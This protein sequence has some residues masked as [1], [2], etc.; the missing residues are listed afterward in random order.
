MLQQALDRRFQ[1]S[2]GK[3]SELLPAGI[4]VVAE[5]LRSKAEG[6]LKENTPGPPGH[7]RHSV[8]PALIVSFYSF[9]SA[10]ALT[11]L[12]GHN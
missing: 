2:V 9:S 6:N 3:L 5:I 8:Q 11:T 1:F 12:I 10:C 7:V 4:R